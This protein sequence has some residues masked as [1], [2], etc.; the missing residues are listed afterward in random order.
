MLP[1]EM[2]RLFLKLYAVIDL[3]F[4]KPANDHL[5]KELD[6]LCHMST[7]MKICSEYIFLHQKKLFVSLSTAVIVW[8]Y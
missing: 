4:T 7:T 2:F 6:C 8:S 3:H 1:F 5:C